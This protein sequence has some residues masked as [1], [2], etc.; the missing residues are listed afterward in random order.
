MSTTQSWPTH[1]P[2]AGPAPETTRQ[3]SRRQVVAGLLL[4]VDHHLLG[5]HNVR[6]DVA[7]PLWWNLGFLAFGAV[8]V[9]VGAAL[10][11]SRPS[12]ARADVI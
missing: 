10:A 1:A 4:G 7:D 9:M 5:V 2:D 6:D 12:P 11:R 3:P 8:L